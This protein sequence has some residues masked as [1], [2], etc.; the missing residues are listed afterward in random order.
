LLRI[1]QDVI[2]Q[3]RVGPVRH[4]LMVLEG[5]WLA[6]F[7]PHFWGNPSYPGNKNDP[8]FRYHITFQP[9]AR[10]SD[11]VPATRRRPVA[12]NACPTRPEDGG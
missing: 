11:L 1:P 10:R 5:N 12:G 3:L 9:G 7:A 2:L 8:V 4:D 6:V